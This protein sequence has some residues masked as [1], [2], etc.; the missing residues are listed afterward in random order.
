MSSQFSLELEC[1][2]SD[3]NVGIHC[4]LMIYKQVGMP[5]HLLYITHTYLKLKNINYSSTR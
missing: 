4:E 1:M 5:A 3:E 2:Y